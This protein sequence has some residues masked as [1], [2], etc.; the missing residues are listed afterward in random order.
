M[1][2]ITEVILTWWV[3]YEDGQEVLLED[4]SDKIELLISGM[5]ILFLKKGIDWPKHNGKG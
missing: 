2:K 1:E 3:R 4:G 5:S